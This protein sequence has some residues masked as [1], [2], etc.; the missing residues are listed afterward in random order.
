MTPLTFVF[1]ALGCGLGAVLRFWLGT[2]RRPHHVPWPTVLANVLGTGLLGAAA[3]LTD[4]AQLSPAAAIIVGSGVAGGLTTFST[5]AVDA[6]VLWRASPARA[7]T[8][9]AATGVA[10][11]V[12]GLAGWWIAQALTHS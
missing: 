2:W 11:T 3:F 6:L 7:V 9:L 1:A 4:S 12:S 8:Y 5:L 10:G